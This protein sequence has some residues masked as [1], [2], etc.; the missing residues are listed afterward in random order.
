MNGVKKDIAIGVISVLLGLGA[1]Q[2]KR[3]T[4]V[5]GNL[6]APFSMASTAITVG[7]SPTLIQLRGQLFPRRKEVRPKRMLQNGGTQACTLAI[8]FDGYPLN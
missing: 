3:P 2:D 5:E 7:L 6:K 8:R 4:A 1:R